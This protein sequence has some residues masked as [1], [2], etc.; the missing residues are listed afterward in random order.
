MP[1]FAIE[2]VWEWTAFLLSRWAFVV[3]LEYLGSLSILVAVFF[4]FHDS[5]NRVKQRH[6]Q[7]WQVI[8]TAQGK[9]GSGGRIEALQELNEDGVPLVGV[10]A[11][12]AFLQGVHLGKAR[13]LRSDFSAADLRNSDFKAADLQD[14]DLHSANFRQSSFE[15]ALLFGARMNDSDLQGTNLSG[16]DLSGAI[17]DNADLRFAIMNNTNWSNIRSIKGANLFGLRNAPNGF[18]QWSVKHGA[19]QVESDEQWERSTA[20]Q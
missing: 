10:D 18:L 19:V 8:N 7:A 2:W 14:S 12:G 9:G 13:L 4:Y 1:F 16:A 15:K 5:G 6:Y 11:S 3:V 17:L 20:S